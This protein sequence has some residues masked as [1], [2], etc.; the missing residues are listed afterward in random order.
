MD[1]IN[2]MN[3][4]N[5]TNASRFA[6]LD[7]LIARAWDDILSTSRLAKA[8][9]EKSISRELYIIYMT[10]TFHYTAHN[11]RNQ[12]MAG[13]V[14]AENPVYAKFCFEHAAE[15]TGHEKMALHDLTKVAGAAEAP[16]LP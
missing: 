12:A 3:Q 13:V 15:E 14:H 8:I 16:A 2:Q 7:K 11:A 6:S 1:Q 4:M 10:E 9:R 5:Q